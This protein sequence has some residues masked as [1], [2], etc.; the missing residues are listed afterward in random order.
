MTCDYNVVLLHIVKVE[1]Y[2]RMK[3]MHL[4]IVLICLVIGCREAYIYDVEE[5]YIPQINLNSE[6]SSDLPVEIR[7]LKS[8]ALGQ[9]VNA[10]P[11]N[12]A[13][14][15]LE[16]T[17]IPGGRA[18]LGFDSKT[19]SYKFPLDGFRL[20]EDQRYVVT[21]V[22]EGFDTIRSSTVIPKPTNFSRIEVISS[23]KIAVD[24]IRNHFE[25]QLAI[26]LQEPTRRPAFYMLDFNRILTEYRVTSNNDTLLTDYKALHRL[27]VKTID[28]NKNAIHSF[29]QSPGV[30]IDESKLSN[31]RMVFTIV[32]DQSLQSFREILKKVSIELR[33]ITPELFWYNEYINRLL[34]S[35]RSG[36]SFP[37]KGYSNVENGNG[38]FGGLS[39][40]NIVIN[41]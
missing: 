3:R 33:T 7:I 29:I 27:N 28:N 41:I 20:N 40:R 6:I 25:I 1:S 34:T 23:R 39:R 2:Y 15:W 37:V 22:T 4:C 13:S 21:A 5:Q 24:P 16:G 8:Q 38:V 10:E 18:L 17:R 19:N 11:M 32:T 31:E 36:Y 30:F 26:E 35:T 9:D 14:V 12:K